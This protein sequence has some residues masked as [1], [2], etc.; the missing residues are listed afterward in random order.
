MHHKCSHVIKLGDLNL[1]L[2]QEAYDNLFM[3]QGL[4]N[5]VLFPTHEW[6][7]LLGPVLS[8]L[9]ETSILCQQRGLVG[10]IDHYAVLAQVKLNMAREDAVP[11]TIW[12]WEMADWSSMRHAIDHMDWEALLVGDAEAKAC[13]IS[14][15]LLDL[16][17]Q[18]IP[19]RKYL[20]RHGDTA[21][22]DYRCRVAAEAKHAAWMRY[23]RRP[24]HQNKASTSG[25][26]Q[27]DGRYL[28]MGEESPERGL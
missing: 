21:W 18:H 22:F 8:D 20:T 6:G 12:L 27:A 15:K 28:Q 7:G 11:R 13:A 2:E 10:S 16:L 4:E 23:K 14:S 25:G 3:V 26:V 19:S 9:P 1:H 24:T 17:Q 5:H